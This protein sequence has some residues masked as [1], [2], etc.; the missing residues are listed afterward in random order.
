[1]LAKP[2]DDTQ[3]SPVV[4]NV[5][6][7][8]NIIE[9]HDRLCIQEFD[10]TYH[11]GVID[12]TLAKHGTTCHERRR[13]LPRVCGRA[14]VLFW[15]ATAWLMLAINLAARAA[16][17]NSGG[18]YSTSKEVQPVVICRHLALVGHPQQASP[19]VTRKNKTNPR[20]RM[21]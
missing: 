20:T 17:V 11:E 14:S 13:F 18:S 16:L 6:Q 3:K 7:Q 2:S 8:N 9:S 12:G 21:Q 19:H 1:M 4:M 15:H 5:K 10:L